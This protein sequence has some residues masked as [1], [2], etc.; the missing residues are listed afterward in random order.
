M[1]VVTIEAADKVIERFHQLQQTE[2]GDLNLSPDTLLVGLL[3]LADEHPDELRSIIVNY[4]AKLMGADF[5]DAAGSFVGR[6][7]R[8]SAGKL[9]DVRSDGFANKRIEEGSS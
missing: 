3:G 6:S 5:S 4:Y 9:H 1:K 7:N 2:E 8:E